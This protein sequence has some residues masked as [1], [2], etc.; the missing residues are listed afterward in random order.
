MADVQTTV[1]G[2][3]TVGVRLAYCADMDT[4]SAPSASAM[5]LLTR[6]NQAGAVSLD[7]QEIDASALED[8]IT[9]YIPGRQDPGGDWTVTIN[10]TD[11]TI[12]EWEAIKGS[13]KVFEVYAPDLSKAFWVR[14]AVPPVIASGEFGQ[15]S[16]KTIE[17]TLTLVDVF[18][19]QDKVTPSV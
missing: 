10:A 13:K 19:W 8:S 15:N 3:S 14:A 17:L 4:W 11:A 9:K 5:T 2:V 6:I 18:G 1:P 7:V 12:T 16:L